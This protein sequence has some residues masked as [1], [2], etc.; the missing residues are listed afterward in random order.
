M[1]RKKTLSPDEVRAKMAELTKLSKQSEQI[2]EEPK[3][4]LTPIQKKIA[5][6]CEKMYIQN[7]KIND[8]NTIDVIG[9]CNLRGYLKGNL[10]DY[11]QFGTIYPHPKFQ[12]TD[13]D[14]SDSPISSLRGCPHTVY[15]NFKC[16]DTKVSSLEYAPKIV[17]STFV[18]YNNPL[19]AEDFMIED[20]CECEFIQT[21]KN[22]PWN[23]KE[24][25]LSTRT[26][27][28]DKDKRKKK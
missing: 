2:K 17:K 23:P 26:I 4:E 19:E 8:D 10:P 7:Y 27:N 11:I 25:G 18:F 5:D 3:K 14:I 15:G 13:F 21:E 6:W 1:G 9:F 22:H 20:I 24:W 16:H 28:K 12:T